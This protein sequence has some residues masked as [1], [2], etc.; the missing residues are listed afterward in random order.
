L[1]QLR[2]ALS[3]EVGQ[4]TLRQEGLISGIERLPAWCENLLYV[5]ETDNTV[6]F[7]HHSIQEFLLV[8]DSGEHGALHIDPDQCD[9]LAGEVCITYV[10]LDNFQT[11]LAERKREPLGP[12]AIKIDPSGIAEQTMQSAIQG[13]V[14]T[15][16]GRLAR[17]LVKTSNTGK[18]TNQRDFALSSPIP[19]TS[20]AQG[21]ADYPFFEYASRNWFKHT[22]SIESKDKNIWR[23]FGQMVQKPPRHSQ[24]E[25]WHSTEWK[26]E[27]MARFRNHDEPRS[28]CFAQV[29]QTTRSG[30]IRSSETSWS[31]VPEFSHLCFAFIYAELNGYWSLA[32]RSFQLLTRFSGDS[33]GLNKLVCILTANKNH[34]ACRNYCASLL[35]SGLD[36]R[37]LVAELRKAIARGISYF[38]ALTNCAPFPP[39]DCGDQP[40]HNSKLDVCHVL[41]NG[42]RRKAEPHVQAFAIVMEILCNGGDVPNIRELGHL[43]DME[44][45]A[46][47]E[48][49]NAHGM[50]LLDVLVQGLLSS[51]N[52]DRIRFSDTP[53]QGPWSRPVIKRILLSD[54]I[55]R[56]MEYTLNPT[57]L[58][59]LN[60]PASDSSPSKQS[61]TE[62]TI[63]FLGLLETGFDGRQAP[64]E[65]YL[66]QYA[67]SGELIKLHGDSIAAIFR[68]FVVPTLWPTY[69]ATYIVKTLFWG[70]LLTSYKHMLHAHEDSFREAVWQNN[71]DVAAALI[72]HQPVSIESATNMGHF[73]S[74]R[75]ALLCE[76]CWRCTRNVVRQLKSVDMHRYSFRLC[77][78]HI[79]M[80]KNIAGSLGGIYNAEKESLLCPGHST[81]ALPEREGRLKRA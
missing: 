21:N 48:A 22:K 69:M 63:C 24:G 58:D 14:G 37:S 55:S 54:S 36:H 41:G 57:F 4:H 59:I 2:E 50:L 1:L 70:S 28:E 77:A 30:V 73:A 81:D 45:R 76:N 34:E 52:P 26:N 23:L 60:G 72:R 39:C 53:A 20:K 19:I 65:E 6:R 42:Y 35:S 67:R 31:A 25:P 16:V 40:P 47:M 32:C 9:K 56:F 61:P 78:N 17:Q 68:N 80:F 43:C 62:Y 64:D 18:T 13:G 49:R 33:D 38:P 51:P 74:I 15:R 12:S 46:M 10:N 71:W 8:P 27:A 5:E 66:H 79:S 44:A 7:S 11:A 75:L 3:I 29:I